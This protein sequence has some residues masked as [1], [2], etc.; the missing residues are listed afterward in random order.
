MA[1]LSPYRSL[2]AARRVALLTHLLTTHRETRALYIQ[3]LVA[4]GGGFRAVT[5][6]PW[7]GERIARE[8]VRLNAETAQDEIE[9]LQ[10]LYVD[11]EPAIQITMLDA[12]GVKHEGGKIDEEL[13][14]PYADAAAVARGAAAVREQHGEDGVHYLRTIARYN[15][16]AWPGLDEYLATIDS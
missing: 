10:L 16:G 2:P 5:M 11:L 9:L 14:P 7:P 1:T 15:L 12:T 8:V 13:E 6:Q 3:R 4:R